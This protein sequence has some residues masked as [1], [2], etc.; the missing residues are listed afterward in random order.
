MSYKSQPEIYRQ[1]LGLI[2][3]FETNQPVDIPAVVS[4]VEELFIDN[5]ALIVGFSQFLPSSSNSFYSSH[6]KLTNLPRKVPKI[7]PSSS[8][9]TPK[10]VVEIHRDEIKQFETSL[11]FKKDSSVVTKC[12]YCH[13]V[14]D[15]RYMKCTQC[16]CCV[17][18]ACILK[19]EKS[20]GPFY[21]NSRH[22]KY[23]VCFACAD[24][25]VEKNSNTHLGSTKVNTFTNYY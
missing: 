6:K 9:V 4:Q 11:Y 3:S 1:F 18:V 2:R 22:A 7:T 15:E 13:N 25:L 20:D 5:E 23:F 21:W 10:D 16:A 17:H 24:S 12:N 14:C 8:K 19:A